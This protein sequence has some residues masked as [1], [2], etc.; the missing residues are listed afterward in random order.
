M[1]VIQIQQ[2][3]KKIQ[4]QHKMKKIIQIQLKRKKIQIRHKM[5]EIIQIQQKMKNNLSNIISNNNVYK[6]NIIIND[7][8]LIKSFSA[9]V[10]IIIIFI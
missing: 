8:S 6:N 9:L 5:R 1:K 2:K 10:N 7:L 4:I 3:R